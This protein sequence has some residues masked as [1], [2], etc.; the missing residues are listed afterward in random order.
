MVPTPVRLYVLDHP[1]AADAL[2][3]LR[4]PDTGP[5]GFRVAAGR[6]AT[7]L[8]VEAARDLPVRPVESPTPLGSASGLRVAAWP[9]LV[10]VLRAGLGML[11]AALGVV[12]GAA[13]AL[14]GLR[15]DE[16]T[17]VAD[18]YC[19]TVPEDLA[20]RSAWVLDPMLATGGTMVEACGLLAER[21]AGPLSALCLIAAPEGLARMAA[22]RPD[23]TVWCGAIDDRLDQRGYIV[24]GLGDAGDRFFGPGA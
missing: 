3:A 15:R 20:G 19:H 16:T 22:D 10:P 11:D 12:P 24:P 13:V 21:G 14:V 7:L 8:A 18:R 2:L 9:L 6:V 4:H 5:A 17:L 1:L 23:V